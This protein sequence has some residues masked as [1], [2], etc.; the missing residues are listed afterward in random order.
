MDLYKQTVVSP[1][2]YGKYLV[3]CLAVF[4]LVLIGCGDKGKPNSGGGSG[5]QSGGVKAYQKTHARITAPALA[6]DADFATIASADK[7]T[8][9]DPHNTDNGAN[10]KVMIQI[11]Q[12][13]LS[14][15][16]MNVD[17]K[18][19]M[20]ELLLEV[21]FAEIE[22]GFPAASQPDFDFIRRII[23][24]DR[25]PEGVSIQILCQAREELIER[26]FEV[27]ET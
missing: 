13:L 11:Y 21:G 19:R 3:I 4:L 23:D 7:A 14:I 25:I 12:N 9:L 15:D 8:T 26:S 18:L 17:E 1:V 22:V 20:Y 16:P 6:D 10:V 24:E 2:R 27:A 5:S